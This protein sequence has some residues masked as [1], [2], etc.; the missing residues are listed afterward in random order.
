MKRVLMMPLVVA[1]AAGALTACIPTNTNQ[2]P[3]DHI[4][5]LMQ[6][7]RSAD[8]Y[9]G[10]LSIQGQPGYEAE[11][12]TGNPD[13]LNPLNPPIVPYHKTVYCD[14][15]DLNHSWNGVHQEVNGGAMDGF[16]AANDSASANADPADPTGARSMGYYDQ[17]D[18]PFYYSL[19]NTFATNDRYFSSLQSQTFPNRLYLLAGTSFG[20]IRNDVAR[21]TQKS[22][23]ELMDQGHV[24]WKIYGDQY[25]LT[26]GS[27]FFKYVADH[28]AG[29]V[30]PMSQYYADA[31]AGRLPHVAFVDPKLVASPKVAN[32]EHPIAN[33]QV[34]Q[35]F[36]ADVTNALMAS[37]EW[38]SSA[39]FFTYDEHGGFYD[40]VAPPAAPVPDNIAPILQAGDTVAAFDHYGVRVPVAVISP[41]A[42]SHYVSHVV[43]DHTSILRF[44]EYRFG[45]PSLTNR[46]AN[47]DPMLDMF[48]FTN[49]AFATPP[50]LAPAVIDPVQLAACPS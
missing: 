42:K 43:D 49:P 6:E 23:F 16:T 44:I 26:Y 34:G 41:Y 8:S 12:V 4:V 39:M 5:V 46:D 45:L 17:S 40:H 7:N 19:Y 9:L 35:K 38:G 48:D 3:I 33:V 11:P 14:S 29:H 27:L 36:V 31:A 47:A 15:S 20:H 13:P 10:Q 22:I 28:A 24:Q 50:T 21:S 18:L 2:L 32:D 30:F 1:V 25:P 37:P